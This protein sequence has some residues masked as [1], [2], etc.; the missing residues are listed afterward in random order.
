M[1]FIQ[2]SNLTPKAHKNRQIVELSPLF[3]KLVIHNWLFMK[4]A[5]YT[6]SVL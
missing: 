3:I 2:T 4:S 5:L 1:S 6:Y